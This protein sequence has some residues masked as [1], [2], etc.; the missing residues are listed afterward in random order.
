VRPPGFARPCPIAQAIERGR[1]GHVAA[2]LG[3]LPDDL[4]HIAVSG[5][6]MLPRRIARHAQLGVHPALPVQMQQVFG[7]LR[8]AINHNRMQNGAEDAFFERFW[9]RGM[10]P[11]RTQVLA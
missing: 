7:R 2:D 11:D 10:M 9:G 6:A 3:E 5:P 8:G 4:N 1:N